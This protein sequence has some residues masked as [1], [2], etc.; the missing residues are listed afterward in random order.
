MLIMVFFEIAGIAGASM[1]ALMA[2]KAHVTLDFSGK[3]YEIFSKNKNEKPSFK[4]LRKHALIINATRRSQR[5]HNNVHL[6][7]RTLVQLGYKKND[8]YVLEGSRSVKQYAES[9]NLSATKESIKET[10]SHLV[11]KLSYEDSLFLYTTNHGGRSPYFLYGNQSTLMTGDIKPKQIIKEEEFSEWFS[12]LEAGQSVMYF[13]QCFSG[14]FAHSL[15]KGNT[16]ALSTSKS[17]KNSPTKTFSNQKL[18]DKQ[19][20]SL[21]TPYFFSAF[22]GEDPNGKSINADL[23]GDG[24]VSV[25]DAFIFAA[26]KD[27]E[28]SKGFFDRLI[29]PTPQLIYE[30]LNA[31][32]TIL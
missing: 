11:N 28:N 10:V 14:G 31:N 19:Y 23:D 26:Q 25:Q 24:I 32:Q 29:N 2:A 3:Q 15:G 12:D 4:P 22:L 6:A 20:S 17:R 9:H 18:F 27:Y 13:N 8:I 7:Y 5:H 1:G 30:N 16:I 21:F